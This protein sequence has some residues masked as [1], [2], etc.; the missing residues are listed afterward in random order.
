ML[1]VCLATAPGVGKTNA[2]LGEAYR[3]RARERGKDVVVGF[4]ETHGRAEPQQILRAPGVTVP[5][6]RGATGSSL[7]RR[8]SC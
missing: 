6:P 4:V 3:A 7:L 8:R 5:S 1:R 2:V